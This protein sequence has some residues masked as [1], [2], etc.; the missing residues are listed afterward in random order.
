MSGNAVW[1]L[2]G[3][4][5]FASRVQAAANQAGLDFRILG[6]LP[7]ELNENE[8]PAWIVIDLATRGGL[9]PAVY[10]TGKPRFPAARWLAYG[11]HVQVGKLAAARQAGIETVITRGQFDAKLPTL[12]EA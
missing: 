10:E 1:F 3:D 8:Q 7:A 11:P 5:M 12:F 4:L 9:L 6:G 2:S